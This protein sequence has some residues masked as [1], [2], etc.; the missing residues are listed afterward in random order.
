M[1]RRYYEAYDERYKQIHRE[2]LLWFSEM[3]SPI[4]AQVMERFGVT[5]SDR[6][7]EL[8]C[9]EGRDA[10]YLLKKGYDVLATDVS[11]AAI[12]CC[13]ALDPAHEGQY[14]ELDCVKGKLDGKYRFIYAVAVVHMLVEDADRDGFYRFIREHLT[15]DGIALICTMGDGTFERRTDPRTAF[16]LQERLHEQSGKTFCIT[17]TSC[18]MVS[19]HTL[20]AELT[21]NDLMLRERGI[22]AVEP[23]FPELMYAVVTGMD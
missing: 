1:D 5:P 2:K 8:G 17:G 20:E 12:A 21:R 22:T 18:R 9:G 16:D 13:R 10:Q 14:Q 4:V 23:D 3:P 6:I 15:R 7:L 19:F 11:P